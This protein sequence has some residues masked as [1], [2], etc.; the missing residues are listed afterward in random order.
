MVVCWRCHQQKVQN[1]CW[2][3]CAPIPSFLGPALRRDLTESSAN[4]VGTVSAVPDSR[5]FEM[6]GVCGEE[7][8]VSGSSELEGDGAGESLIFKYDGESATESGDRLPPC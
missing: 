4:S 3:S 8:L 2:H 6:R 5:T 7:R 1:R